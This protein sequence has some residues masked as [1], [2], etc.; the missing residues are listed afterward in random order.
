MN[1]MEDVEVDAHLQNKYQAYSYQQLE[2]MLLDRLNSFQMIENSYAKCEIL[3]DLANTYLHCNKRLQALQ[4]LEQAEELIIEYTHTEF[5]SAVYLLRAHLALLH[6]DWSNIH[7]LCESGITCASKYKKYDRIA[8]FYFILL[9]LALNDCLYDKAIMFGKL[10]L[11]FIK[12]HKGEQSNFLY[13]VSLFLVQAYVALEKFDEAKTIIKKLAT[14]NNLT[15][16][17]ELYVNIA[18]IFYAWIDTA[19]VTY[20]EQ[21]HDELQKLWQMNQFAEVKTIL[22]VVM[23]YSPVLYATHAQYLLYTYALQL[24]EDMIRIVERLDYFDKIRAIQI[25]NSNDEKIGYHTGKSFRK[26][27]KEQIQAADEEQFIT[28][29][30]FVIQVNKPDLLNEYLKIKYDYYIKIDQAFSQLY[31]ESTR[32]K[33]YPSSF[34][35]MFIT[36]EPLDVHMIS[37]TCKNY[38]DDIELEL[39]GQHIVYRTHMGAS[40]VQKKAIKSLQSLYQEADQ[41]LYYAKVMKKTLVIYGEEG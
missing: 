2:N 1:K 11:H 28:I 23:K 14:K 6:N 35:S 37:K 27:L 39:E 21:L 34:C 33:Y 29:V 16:V 15:S 22:F 17:N 13:S 8:C 32:G 24:D 9:Q 7:E 26:L 12:K 30:T 40:S 18:H 4:M 3:L 38:L 41:S 25:T 31:P 19:D 5:L 36:D 10:V 20:E